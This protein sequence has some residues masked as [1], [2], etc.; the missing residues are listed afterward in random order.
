[1]L[2]V[3]FLSVVHAESHYAGG[4]LA[5]CHY[6]ECCGTFPRVIILSGVLNMQSVA[7]Q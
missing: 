4:R 2:S 5:E 1:M 7:M 3:I 6:S